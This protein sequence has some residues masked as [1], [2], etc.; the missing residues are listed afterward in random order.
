MAASKTSFTD[1]VFWRLKYNAETRTASVT[2]LSKRSDQIG[3]RLAQ[4]S[5]PRSFGQIGT[6]NARGNPAL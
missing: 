5:R 4:R 2:A 3:D 6:T 1:L